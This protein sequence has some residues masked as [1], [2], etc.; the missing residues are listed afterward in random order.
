MNNVEWIEPDEPISDEVIQNVER[1]FE[2][3]FPQDYKECVKLFNGGYPE[4]DVF[5]IDEDN[6]VV[7]SCLLSFTNE[8]ANILE[9]YDIVSEYLPEGIFPFAKDPFGNLICFDYR[10]DKESPIIIFYDHETEDE[11]NKFLRICDTF[12][13]LIERLHEDDE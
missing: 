12:T 13:E 4:P 5:N 9:V 10:Q 8:E 2:I 7:F 1:Y 11:E 3:N 6:D